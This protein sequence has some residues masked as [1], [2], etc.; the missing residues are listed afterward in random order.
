M[1]RCPC[2]GDDIMVIMLLGYA[3]DIDGVSIWREFGVGLAVMGSYV[4]LGLAY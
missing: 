1:V 4:L 3:G 2:S